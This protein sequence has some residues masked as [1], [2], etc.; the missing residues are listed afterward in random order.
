MFISN[1]VKIVSNAYV[2]L[3][4]FTRNCIKTIL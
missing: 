3:A 2:F 4:P 1:N